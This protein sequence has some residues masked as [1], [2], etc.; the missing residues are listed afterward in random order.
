[1]ARR[2]VM[3]TAGVNM[4]GAARWANKVLSRIPGCTR[5]PLQVMRL[6]A[7]VLANGDLNN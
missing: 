6:N 3:D 5:K 4:V 7:W 2:V 1:M